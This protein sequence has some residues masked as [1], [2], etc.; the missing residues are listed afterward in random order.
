MAVRL[1]VRVPRGSTTEVSEH[2]FLRPTIV[3]GRSPECDLVLP[4]DEVRVSRQHVRIERQDKAYVLVDLGSRNGTLLNN[5]PIPAESSHTLKDGDLVR[6]GNV[7]VEIVSVTTSDAPEEAADAVRKE[8]HT[9]ARTAP[10]PD[11]RADAALA[12]LTEIARR[13]VGGAEPRDADQTKRLGEMVNNALDALL[14]G[15]FQA[16][17]ARREFEGEFDAHVTMAFQRDANPIKQVNELEKFKRFA[18]DF[19]AANDPREAHEAL[20]RAVRDV[21][22]HQM[23]LL[24][25]MQQVLDAIAKRLDPMEIEKTAMAKAGLL[26]RMSRSRLAWQ[27]YLDTYSQFLAESTKMFNE[28]IYPN[29]QKG[30]LLSHKNKTSIMRSVADLQMKAEAV[31]KMAREEAARPDDAGPTS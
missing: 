9:V 10:L 24:A 6:M 11:A 15:L 23:G 5:Q 17:A 21:N 3:V 1:L 18:L 30:Y 8:R 29:L 22:Q 20:Q 7:E 13:F 19:T 31:A 27:A 2:T 25:G 28:M 14:D 26:G 12:A 16:L 4:G